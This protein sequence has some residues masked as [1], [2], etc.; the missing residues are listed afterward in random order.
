M[1]ALIYVSYPRVE[2][3]KF[4]MDFYLN[5]HMKL[6]EKHWGPCGMKDW[7]VVQFEKDDASG[8]L[9]LQPRLCSLC[10]SDPARPY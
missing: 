8:T 4:D 6:V 3:A 1:P 9:V 7:T 5:T 10:G 2:G